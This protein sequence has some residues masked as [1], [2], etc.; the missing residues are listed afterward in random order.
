M[1]SR[2]GYENM[3]PKD[4]VCDFETESLVLLRTPLNPSIARAINPGTNSEAG[5]N[6]VE[7]IL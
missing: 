6:F 2:L 3:H 5:R 4:L 1:D 7:L